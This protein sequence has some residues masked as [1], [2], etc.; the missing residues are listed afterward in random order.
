MAERIKLVASD[1]RPF[2]TLTLTTPDG[3]PVD[4][5]GA[6]VQVFF[7]A[8]GATVLTATLPCVITNASS[9]NCYFNFPGTTLVGLS[10]AYEGEIEVTFANGDKQSVYDL[11]KFVVRDQVG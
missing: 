2:V 1:N 4:L 6:S 10:G 3:A 11:L 8:A 7:R 5:T 9:G